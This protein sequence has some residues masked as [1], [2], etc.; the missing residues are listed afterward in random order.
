MILSTYLETPLSA[1]SYMMMIS[2]YLACDTDH[3]TVK[4]SIKTINS[5]F[6]TWYFEAS[7]QQVPAA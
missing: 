5:W 4:D 6:K 7:Q 1:Q 3:T 2:K